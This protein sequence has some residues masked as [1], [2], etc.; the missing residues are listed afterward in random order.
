MKI[1][2]SLSWVYMRRNKLKKILKDAFVFGAIVFASS[3]FIIICLIIFICYI[4][5]VGG[6]E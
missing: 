2:E 6:F 1:L 3:I 5:C 4:E